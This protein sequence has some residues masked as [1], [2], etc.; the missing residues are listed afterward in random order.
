MK[1]KT[2]ARSPWH[3][4][5]MDCEKKWVHIDDEHYEVLVYRCGD[6]YYATYGI[7]HISC[8]LRFTLDDIPTN[9]PYMGELAFDQEMSR[10]YVPVGPSSGA[11]S[12]APTASGSSGIWSRSNA[13]SSRLGRGARRRSTA[14]PRICCVEP[15]QTTE[16]VK[17]EKSGTWLHR[18]PD[19]DFTG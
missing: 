17:T 13:E 10:M 7:F 15:M 3:R 2:K 11:W 16:P 5:Y 9:R 8:F 19:D 6:E 4:C 12:R 1:S 14:N 18:N